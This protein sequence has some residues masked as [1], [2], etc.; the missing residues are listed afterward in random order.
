M[1]IHKLLLI[2]F[3]CIGIGAS[4]QAMNN[5]Q[6]NQ[7][8]PTEQSQEVEECC[9]CLEQFSADN[10]ALKLPHCIHKIC[11]GC[12]T[13]MLVEMGDFKCPQC[14]RL[15]LTRSEIRRSLEKTMNTMEQSGVNPVNTLVF[16]NA[17]KAQ[18]DPLVTTVNCNGFSLSKRPVI[19][20]LLIT[21]MMKDEI[22]QFELL[23][24]REDLVHLAVYARQAIRSGKLW[25]LQITIDVIEQ[26]K[27][28]LDRRTVE[29]W[30][31]AARELQNH[32]EAFREV[33]EWLENSYN[34]I[35]K[36]LPK[37]KSLKKSVF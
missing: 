3:V 19:S 11:G 29:D 28:P 23:L 2:P 31:L 35:A 21:K 37:S 17:L 18:H 24:E 32:G 13:K 14:R 12:D 5:N 30:I 25:A 27:A 7:P 4:L 36:S 1:K 33:K 26:R 8:A 16:N 20:D 34:V 6:S 9:V 15:N 10:S 22:A